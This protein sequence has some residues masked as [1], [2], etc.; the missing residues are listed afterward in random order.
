M[1]GIKY[2]Y[3]IELRDRGAH[4]FLLPKKEILPTGQE[5]WAAIIKLGSALMNLYN[6][7]K[8]NDCITVMK[9][10]YDEII[11]NQTSGDEIPS[12]FLFND[13]Y[14]LLEVILQRNIAISIDKDLGFINLYIVILLFIFKINNIYSCLNSCM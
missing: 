13:Q 11:Q 5:Q 7:S 8:V 3:L 10:D 4:D 2:S 14:N 6:F 12:S 9:Y 1:A